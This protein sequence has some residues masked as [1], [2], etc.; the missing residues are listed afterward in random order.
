M[1]FEHPLRRMLTSLL[2]KLTRQKIKLKIQMY[3]YAMIV[4]FFLYHMR[5]WRQTNGIY[6]TFSF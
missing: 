4:R 6:E 3:R 5:L 1:Y 2:V